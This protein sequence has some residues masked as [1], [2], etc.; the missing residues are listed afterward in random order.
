MHG[1]HPIHSYLSFDIYKVDPEKMEL[2]LITWKS[3]LLRFLCG[4]ELEPI[5]KVAI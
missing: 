3:T 4:V 5:M 1:K 2:F